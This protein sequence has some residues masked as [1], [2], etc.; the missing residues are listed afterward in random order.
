MKTIIILLILT[1]N[2]MAEENES[3]F[4]SKFQELKKSDNSKVSKLLSEVKTTSNKNHL[5]V[6]DIIN[7]I[8]IPSENQNKKETIEFIQYKIQKSYNKLKKSELTNKVLITIEKNG[9]M[10]YKIIKKSGYKIFDEKIKKMLDKE[11][12]NKTINNSK[13][14]INIVMKFRE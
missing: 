11:T 4:K 6:K 14:E 7:D 1:I 10:K 5:T 8:T 9:K 3:R 13:E 2:I 12:K